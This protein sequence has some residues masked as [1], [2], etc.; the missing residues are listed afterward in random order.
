LKGALGQLLPKSQKI[1]KVEHHPALPYQ[2]A[3][4][5][6]AALRK[7]GGMTSHGLEFMLLTACRTGEVAAARW[8]EVDFS[9]NVWTVPAMRMKA[10]NEHR[11]PL[12][13][14]AVEILTVLKA[15]A[16]NDFVFPSHSIERNSHM[17]LG[18]CL[19]AMKRMP[20]FEGY[21]PHGLRSTFRDWAAETTNFANETL[22]LA[23]A[24]TIKNKAEAAYRRKDQLEKRSKLMQ[25]WQKFV[26][27]SHS[28]NQLLKFERSPDA[29]ES[30]AA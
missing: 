28:T 12:S 2:R 27:T 8:D 4:E 14:R 21:T 29:K 1:K 17:S 26:E 25:Q 16:Q 7:Q 19:V 9:T 5:F 20:G 24:H 30:K 10:G 6:V 23:L 15:K 3:N 22:E 11:V 18:S 13:S